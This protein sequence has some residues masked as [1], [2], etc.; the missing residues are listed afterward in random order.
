[1]SEASSERELGQIQQQLK[2]F[3][4]KFDQMSEQ[5]AGFGVELTRREERMNSRL[6]KTDED[7]QL[8]TRAVGVLAESVRADREVTSIKFAAVE[9]LNENRFAN[10]WRYVAPISGGGVFLGGAGV[11]WKYFAG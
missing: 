6:T 8:V 9:K 7:I 5:T 11:A 4:H 1:M 10:I 2:E 3:G